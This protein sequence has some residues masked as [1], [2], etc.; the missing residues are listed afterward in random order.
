MDAAIALAHCP[1]LPAVVTAL[2]TAATKD[3]EYLV[4]F[5]AERRLRALA[6]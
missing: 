4:R 2:R 6:P 1:A 3:R 5:H